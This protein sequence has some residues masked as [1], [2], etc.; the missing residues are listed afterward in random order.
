M[1]SEAQYSIVYIGFTNCVVNVFVPML[2]L[3][4]LN[5]AIYQVSEAITICQVTI[6]RGG[7]SNGDNNI[8]ARL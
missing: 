1:R 3:S 8:F 4:L 7:L 5:L 6:T 2:L